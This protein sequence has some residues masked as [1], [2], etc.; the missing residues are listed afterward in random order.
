MKKHIYLLSVM[1]VSAG[2]FACGGGSSK[3]SAVGTD[4][5]QR[6]SVEKVVLS[7]H[8]DTV[9]ASV[10]NL[11][12][13]K[14][15]TFLTDI[16]GK[17]A[18]FGNLYKDVDGV[19]T[20]RGDPSRETSF[21]GKIK[22]TPSNVKVEWVFETD[23]GIT[24]RW[25]GGTGWTGQPLYVHW[26]DEQ[27]KRIKKEAA[28]FVK[29]DLKNKEIIVGS[30]AGKVF[31]IDYESGKD[32]RTPYNINNPIKGTPA[33]HPSLNGNIFVGQGFNDNSPFGAVIF[34]LFNH[35]QVQ[36]FGHDRNARRAWNA[37]DS[38]PVAVG[39][40][41]FRPGENG[42]LYKFYCDGNEVK[43]HST[44]RY[45]GA[46]GASPGMESSLAVHRNYGYIGDNHGNI[47]C[48]NLDNLN[49][50][51]HY[52]NH[53][54]TD[55]SVVVVE[56]AGVPFV[57]TGCEVDKQ[58]ADGYSFFTKLNG[59][60]GEEVWSTKIACH[61]V[62]GERKLDSGM[63]STPLVGH[64]DCEGLIFS[65]FVVHKDDKDGQLIAF[66]TK[67]GKVIYRVETKGY[68]WSSPIAFYNEKNEMFIFTG[69]V[70]GDVYL[71]RGKTGELLHTS[72]VGN[73]FE[74]SPIAIDNKVICGSR[75]TQIYK[76]S[77]E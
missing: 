59:L 49:V 67:S 27:L 37:Y 72:H 10:G 45:R 48:I 47:L 34:N 38:S 36:F 71:F 24:P 77:I 1:V 19:L 50:V 58:G 14:V 39:Q 41:M 55:A 74:S 61:C 32:S 68:S 12:V 3:N 70:Y 4:S 69:D 17:L 13:I 57:Y 42:T 35:K 22:G 28:Q 52:F 9:F 63:L 56:E 31:F 30:L 76:M 33:I 20:F 2:L 46:Y 44:L 54:D 51:W 60:N 5:L 7:R 6:D 11:Q 65:N 16:P 21:S 73:N 40:F 75:G 43:L 18:D 8:P 25:N 23:E 64:G 26:S 29:S 62:G 53:D 15:D 66:D